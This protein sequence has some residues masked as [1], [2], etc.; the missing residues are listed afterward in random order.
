MDL[1][2]AVRPVFIPLV[3]IRRLISWRTLDLLVLV[4]FSVSLIWFN[5]G[6]IYTSVPLVYP[7]LAYLA[8]RMALIG[9]R[10]LRV[11]GRRRRGAG[12]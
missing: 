6:E 3:E 11:R 5:D 9:T 12:G 10:R 7:P 2:G 4:S 1:V 8:V